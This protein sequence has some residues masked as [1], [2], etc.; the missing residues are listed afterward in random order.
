MKQLKIESLQILK[1]LLRIDFGAVKTWAQILLAA[2]LLSVSLLWEADRRETAQTVQ[3][4]KR[5]V[6]QLRDSVRII[7][8]YQDER[9]N[10]IHNEVRELQQISR[11][12]TRLVARLLKDI[13]TLRISEAKALK[14]IDK[15]PN[16]QLVQYFSTLKDE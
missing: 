13:E 1:E 6:V 15:M 9:V 14:A 7:T 2:I 12:S 16:S 5:E 3:A 11:E 10:V 8:R 4:V